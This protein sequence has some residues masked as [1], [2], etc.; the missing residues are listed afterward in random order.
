MLSKSYISNILDL[1]PTTLHD[2]YVD[3][4]LDLPQ[5]HVIPWVATLFSKTI[6][7]LHHLPIDIRMLFTNY[8]H[9]VDNVPKFHAKLK[10][11]IIFNHEFFELAFHV[12]YKSGPIENYYTL[13]HVPLD[14]FPKNVK[15]KFLDQSHKDFNLTDHLTFLIVAHL[16]F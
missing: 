8:R 1:V 15:K 5:L 3:F 12:Q 13:L 4:V 11:Q 14:R 16:S 10:G 9:A 2:F 6:T 7:R